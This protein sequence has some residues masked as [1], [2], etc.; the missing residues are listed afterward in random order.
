MPQTIKLFSSR[1]RVMRPKPTGV[2]YLLLLLAGFLP[3][4]V[5]AYS[6]SVEVT[7]GTGGRVAVPG[8]GE[9]L[10]KCGWLARSSET[11]SLFAVPDPGYRFAGW[12]GECRDTLGPLCTLAADRN[13]ETSVR[14]EPMDAKAG[15]VK[16]L[17]LVHRPG[18]H[19]SVW[20]D[21]V[22]RY[23]DNRCPVIF[24]GVLLDDDAGN[25]ANQ[26]F[27]YRIAL[28]YYQNFLQIPEQ[29]AD[30]ASSV[31]FDEATEMPLYQLANEIQ[32]ALLGIAN[33]HP[34]SSFVVVGQGLGGLAS[35]I[36]VQDV[37]DVA[38]PI[39]GVLA[40]GGQAPPQGQDGGHDGSYRFGS[41]PVPVVPLNAR[42]DQNRKLNWALGQLAPAW[43]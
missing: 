1:Q 26:V 19:A 34:H 6:L 42:P 5:L 40:L 23:F 18:G 2:Q 14:F 11:L 43:W 12:E 16:A 37:G 29:P 27:C 9:C 30:Q 24:G 25:S 8:Q 32:A 31:S 21:F 7:G 3:V 10:A 36:L 17:L 35:Q 4:P 15:P 39:I 13:L 22:S 41:L 28:G 20:N 33:R 38:G